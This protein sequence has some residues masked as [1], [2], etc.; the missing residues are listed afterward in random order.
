MQFN[1]IN[2]KIESYGIAYSLVAEALKE[3]PREM[4]QYKPAPDRWSIHEIIIHLADSEANSYCRFRKIIAEPGGLIVG[5]EQDNWANV[6]D[7]HAQ[8]TDE[9]LDLFR[10]LRKMTFELIKTL[11]EISWKNYA[12]H[13]EHGK[14]HLTEMLDIYERHIPGHIDQMRKVFEHWRKNN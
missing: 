1:E 3:F 4:W 7:Y 14:L 11:P 5:Y 12:I 6:L 8:N 2:A 9:A 13:T 10:L